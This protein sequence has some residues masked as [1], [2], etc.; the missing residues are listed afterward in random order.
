MNITFHRASRRR[1]S[2]ATL[3]AIGFAMAAFTVVAPPPAQAFDVS[4][5]TEIEGII[6]E[7]LLAN[8]EIMLEVQSALEKKQD[9]QK[10]LSQAR[11]LSEMKNELYSSEH[12][13]EIG[14]PNAPVTVVEFYDYNCG[15]CQRALGDM[16]KFVEQDKSV[17][18]IL[19][20]FPVLGE[21]SLQAHK[22]SQ[23]FNRLMPEK[24]AE[25]H[26]LLLGS[27]GRKDGDVALK[28]AESLGADIAAVKAESEKPEILEGLKEAYRLA[29]GLGITGTPS[30]VVGDE[31]VFGA[32]GFDALN[33]KVANL[34]S[35]GKTIC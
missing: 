3:A 22:I 4:Q 18:F 6:R 31:V 24:A 11:T 9:E 19:K 16:N 20:E 30:Y 33:V 1:K 5:K 7:Y 10:K 13:V 25:F 35:C 8:P 34:K 27:P 23:A 17:R 14:D 12:Q 15:F 28:V 26:Q 21:A 29:D 2:S 32:V